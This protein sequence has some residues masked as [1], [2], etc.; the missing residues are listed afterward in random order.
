MPGEENE[1]GRD[2]SPPGHCRCPPALAGTGSGGGVSFLNLARD[3]P[4]CDN[5]LGQRSSR[6]LL[7][8]DTVCP[9]GSPHPSGRDCTSCSQHLCLS[10]SLAG[11]PSPHS[12]PGTPLLSALRDP[13]IRWPPCWA[14]AARAGAVN[15][16]YPLCQPQWGAR[17]I[18][19]AQWCTRA[20]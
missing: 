6:C 1:L 5:V 4:R 15:S 17:H 18:V 20:R 16:L 13:R 11:N 9:Q 3:T 19:G 7:E 10:F 8:G 12:T 14:E 2:I